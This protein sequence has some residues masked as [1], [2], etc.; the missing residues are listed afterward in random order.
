MKPDMIVARTVADLR[1][2]LLAARTGNKRIGFVPTMGAFHA[3]HLHLMHTAREEC[4]VTVVSLF[5]NPTQFGD[6]ADLAAYPRNDARDEEMA[7]NAGV[8]VMFAPTLHE[9]YPSGYDALVEV[10]GVTEPLEGK[11]RGLA[12]FRGVTT[13]VAKLFNIV[14]PHAAYFGQKDA[15]QVAVIRQMIRDLNFPIELVVCPTMRE[16]DGLA[17]S[18]RNTRLNAEARVQAVAL[19]ESLHGILAMIASGNSDTASLLL[20]A[21]A[22]LHARGIP[23]GDIEYLE[24]VDNITLQPV[25]ALGDAPVLFAIAARVGGVR[26]IDN[27]VF[28]E[29][30]S[31]ANG[32]AGASTLAP[33]SRNTHAA[34]AKEPRDG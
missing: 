10:G 32:I 5:V 31:G 23:D 18:S 14:Q 25:A 13:V 33:T 9:M 4:D 21:R 3:G 26:L 20:E 28:D 8:D 6:P 30:S 17:M 11:A 24:A 1:E 34:H 29:S 7:N 22:R 19:S 15:Q 27:V 12:H 2:A 16:A